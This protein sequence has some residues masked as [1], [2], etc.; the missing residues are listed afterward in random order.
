MARNY[1]WVR[2]IPKDFIKYNN[3]LTMIC[4]KCEGKKILNIKHWRIYHNIKLPSP[5]ELLKLME[6]NELPQYKRIV[7]MEKNKELCKSFLDKT[8][9]LVT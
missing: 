6:K 5:T 8:K 2:A 1:P 3:A 7:K 4:P 9:P